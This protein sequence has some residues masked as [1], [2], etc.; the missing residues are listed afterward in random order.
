MQNIEHRTLIISGHFKVHDV[1]QVRLLTFAD[2]L[3]PCKPPQTTPRRG[4]VQS[5]Q[6]VVRFADRQCFCAIAIL[7]TFRLA[8]YLGPMVMKRFRGNRFNHMW[9]SQTCYFKDAWSDKKCRFYHAT[10]GR[11]VRFYWVLWFP[12]ALWDAIQ[13]KS[14]ELGRRLLG[15]HHNLGQSKVFRICYFWGC[16]KTTFLW[17]TKKMLRPFNLKWLNY[18][19]A[20]RL[21]MDLVVSLFL[22]TVEMFAKAVARLF[23]GPT[24]STE[25]RSAIGAMALGS[26]GNA[27]R[28]FTLK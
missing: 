26:T 23:P 21:L 28:E 18:Q 1:L 14:R 3:V 11:A 25:T 4:F 6:F 27:F 13:H 24:I 20:S 5:L 19:V 10:A 22:E 15:Q 8:K 9:R 7:Y 12:N 17:S 16:N 2:F